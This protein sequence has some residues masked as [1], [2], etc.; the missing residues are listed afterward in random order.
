MLGPYLAHVHVKNA[1][2]YPDKYQAD[3]SLAWMCGWTGLHRG[4]ANMTD[5]VRALRAVGYDDW[6]AFE[7][8]STDRPI[9][10]RLQENLIFM[11]NVVAAVES[12]G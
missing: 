8:F 7:D 5:L 12:E 9:D 2:W 1:R 10:D 3:G 6:I 4:V 11:K